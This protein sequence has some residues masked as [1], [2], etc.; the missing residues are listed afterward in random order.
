MASLA[1]GRLLKRTASSP[2]CLMNLL[3]S[4][5]QKRS[6]PL[7][8][9]T[10]TAPLR[11]SLTFHYYFLGLEITFSKKRKK[12]MRIRSPLP[13]YK[14]EVYSLKINNHTKKNKSRHF[15]LYPR[16][17]SLLA[18][19]CAHQSLLSALCAFDTFFNAYIIYGPNYSPFN[20]GNL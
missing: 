13:S 17:F 7:L 18:H 9:L 11:F 4:A 12:M 19:T 20:K 14:S 6:P 16:H 3:I 5:K 15:P 1:G 8:F 10:W 2:H